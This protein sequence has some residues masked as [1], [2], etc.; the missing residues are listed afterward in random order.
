MGTPAIEFDPPSGYAFEPE[1]TGPPPRPLPSSIEDGPYARRFRANMTRGFTFGSLCLL[2]RSVPGVDTLAYYFLPFGHLD[3]I[4]LASVAITAVS[5]AQYVLRLGPFRYVRRGEAIV[6]RIVQLTIVEVPLT[7]AA[8][9]RAAF[10]YRHPDT[11]AIARAVARSNEFPPVRADEHALPFK[12]GDYATAVYLPGRRFERSLQLYAF[13]DLSPRVNTQS[14]PIEESSRRSAMGIFALMAITLLFIAGLYAMERY[15]P[16]ELVL[17]RSAALAIGGSVLTTALFYFLVFRR[18]RRPPKRFHTI[19]VASATAL[20]GGFLGV[21]GGFGANAWL[22]RSPAE[23]QPATVIQYDEN[24]YKY[25]VRTYEIRYQIAGS[26]RSRSLL[27]T[28]EHIR[29]FR[30]RRAVVRIRSG[31]LGWPWVGSLDPLAPDGA[32]PA[33]EP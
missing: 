30:D 16:L 17:E 31:A 3:W 26:A 23:S 29:R 33:P 4:G 18:Q 22:D 2:L 10:V 28:V 24:T 11:G 15:A 1:L 13:L 9:H 12:V 25:L 32:T 21:A 5:L 7:H 27:T 14:V 8:A 20:I 6:V 19:L